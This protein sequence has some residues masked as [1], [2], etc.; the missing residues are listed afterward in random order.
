M[1][2]KPVKIFSEVESEDETG[3]YLSAG[4]KIPGSTAWLYPAL[5]LMRT[6]MP[7]PPLEYLRSIS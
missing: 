4:N 5:N 6:M 3:S 1:H 7:K 2:M